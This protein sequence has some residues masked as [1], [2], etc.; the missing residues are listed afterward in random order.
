MTR[1]MQWILFGAAIVLFTLVMSNRRA[2]AWQKIIM[3]ILGAAI[4]YM[5]IDPEITNVLAGWAGIW[6]GADLVI[7]LAIIFLSFIVVIFYAPLSQF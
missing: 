4:F 6:R 1:I 2:G 5:I 3:A 7:Y